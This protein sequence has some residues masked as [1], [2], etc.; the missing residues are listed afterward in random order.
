M[1]RTTSLIRTPP[2]DELTQASERASLSVLAAAAL[3]A[4]NALLAEH[5]GQL[6]AMGADDVDDEPT[7]AVTLVAT[8][9]IDHID[10]LMESLLLYEATLCDHLRAR[11]YHD[12]IF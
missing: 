9:V 3:C 12:L 11:N 8:R 2:I 6:Q 10:D 5:S 4:R 7:P 1:T